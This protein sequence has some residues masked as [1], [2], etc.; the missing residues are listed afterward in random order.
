MFCYEENDNE[1]Y[2][3]YI[4]DDEEDDNDDSQQEEFGYNGQPIPNNDLG[5]AESRPVVVTSSQYQDPRNTLDQY[6]PSELYIPNVT[7]SGIQSQGDSYEQRSYPAQATNGGDKSIEDMFNRIDN[8]IVSI[9]NDSRSYQTELLAPVHNKSQM[10]QP[11]KY[12]PPVPP[13]DFVKF[14]LSTNYT[15]PSINTYNNSLQLMTLE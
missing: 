12:E 5:E 8:T 6:K 11:S 14:Q 1:L 15:T 7:Y 2:L 4:L 3:A 13:Y 10:S 9:N